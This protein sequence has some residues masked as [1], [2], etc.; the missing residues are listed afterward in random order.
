MKK[1]YEKAGDWVIGAILQDLSENFPKASRWLRSEDFLNPVHR[2]IFRGIESLHENGDDAPLDLSVLYGLLKAD[3]LTLAKYLE[4]DIPTAAGLDYWCRAVLEGSRK[5]KLRELMVEDDFDVIMAEAIFED[6]RGLNKAG[7]LLYRSLE[8]ISPLSEDLRSRI[9]TGFLDLDRNILFG[10]GHLMI[11]SGKTSLGKTSLGLQVT[12][13]I[14]KEKPVGIVS[15]EMTGEEI[16]SRLENSFSDLPGNVFISDPSALSTV[17]FKQIC[18]AMKAERGVE[19]VL[20]DYLQLMREREDFRSRHLEVSHIIRKI[21][22]IAKE[23]SLAMIVISQLSRRVD[24]RGENSLPSLSDLKESGDLEYSADEIL[25]LH[26]PMKGDE[27][28]RGAN[29]K[30]LILAK[31]RWGSTGK[32]KI[33]WNGPKTKFGN[34]MEGTEGGEGNGQ[35]T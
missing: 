10:L 22:E 34:F 2:Q 15:L 17:E 14:S 12:Y 23:L 33:F 27:D 13:H 21:K 3:G 4:Q 8:H 31:N 9:K 24:S 1:D 29:I 19:L 5:R 32:M 18:K 20:L 26:Q 35:K 7:K 6:L 30:L 28:Y 16:R 11:I 25:F